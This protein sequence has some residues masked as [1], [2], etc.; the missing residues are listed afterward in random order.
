M[1]CVCNTFFPLN[2]TNI[3]NA[4]ETKS[5]QKIEYIFLISRDIEISFNLQD[6]PVF[7]PNLDRDSNVDIIVFRVYSH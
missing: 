2:K 7:R 4:C 1:A 6:K 3:I 5:G